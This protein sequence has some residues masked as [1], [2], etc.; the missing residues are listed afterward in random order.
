MA[1]INFSKD[2]HA[3]AIN[4]VRK[5]KNIKAKIAELEAD[6]D[7]AKAVIV[8][9]MGENDTAIA[10]VGGVSLTITNKDITST[11]LDSKVLKAKYPAIAKECSNT[12]TSPRF[13]I[14]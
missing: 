1:T 9:A 7:S 4:A 2:L 14:K 12:T 8:S 13:T 3:D 10:K 5:Y 6:L 11:R